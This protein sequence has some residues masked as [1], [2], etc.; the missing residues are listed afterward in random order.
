MFDG[1]SDLIVLP[2]STAGTIT[3]FVRDKLIHY[4]IPRPR[5]G[6]TLGDVQVFPFEGGE[7]IAQFVAF[8]ASV[9]GNTT[10]TVAITLIGSQLGEQTRQNDSIRHIAAPLLG[11]G[12]GGLQSEK[13]VSSLREGFQS[14]AHKDANLV[15]N[16][17]RTDV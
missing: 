11:A 9:K 13:T 10:S 3:P 6:M 12:A 1:P 7:N 15:I 4:R 16:V 14:T 2:C 5:R 8:A 17:L